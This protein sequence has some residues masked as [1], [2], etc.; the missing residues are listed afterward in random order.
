[1]I[2]IKYKRNDHGHPVGVA[3][4]I[5]DGEV[6]CSLCNKK[7]KWNRE[8]ALMI[9]TRRAE[10]GSKSIPDSMYL[11]YYEMYERSFRYFH[12]SDSF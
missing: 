3:V 7:D 1:M 11:D 5:G 4:A 10:A 12:D 8:K 6:G 9:A 2:L